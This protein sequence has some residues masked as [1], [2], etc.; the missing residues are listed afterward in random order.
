MLISLLGFIIGIILCFCLVPLARKIGLRMGIVDL[1][2]YRKIHLEPTPC[3][4]GLAIYF[5][6]SL[7]LG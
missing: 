1:P 7:A 4:G 5:A 2:N 3:S 6:F